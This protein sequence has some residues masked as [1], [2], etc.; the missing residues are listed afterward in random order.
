MAFSIWSPNELLCFFMVLMR[1]STLMMLLP[2]FGDKTI[3]PT[4]K[5]LLS[6]STAAILFPI[7]RANGSIKV[8]DAAIWS[9]TT[10]KLLI[11]L[12][13]ELLVGLAIGFA[14]Q[15]VFHAIQIAGDFMAQFM[16][17]SMAS[18]YDPHMESQTVVL[19]QLLSALAMLTFLSV[20]GHHLLFRAMIETFHLIPQGHLA[21]GE[22]FKNSIIQLE[23]SKRLIIIRTK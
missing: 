12:V 22:A 4:V 3:P 13:S 19:G 7:L 16:G 15:L 1:I 20:D 23:N 18:Q 17:M 5:V 6:L 9:E 11:T 14:S 10:G 8:E 21:M 2:I